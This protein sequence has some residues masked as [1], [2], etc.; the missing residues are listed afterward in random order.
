ML[1]SE[2]SIDEKQS[3]YEL[4]MIMYSSY[5][6]HTT[7]DRVVLLLF[8]TRVMHTRLASMSSTSCSL[9]EACESV[10]IQLIIEYY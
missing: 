6:A 1:A 5:Y 4:L 10:C 3:K 2:A 8:C 7:C 9:Q